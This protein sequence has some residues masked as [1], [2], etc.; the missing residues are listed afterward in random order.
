[1][2]TAYEHHSGSGNSGID[3]SRFGF[4]PALLPGDKTATP[5]IA[6]PAR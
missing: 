4:C 6:Y 1:V 2:L 3:I 5:E